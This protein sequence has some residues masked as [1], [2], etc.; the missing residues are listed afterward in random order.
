MNYTLTTN[1]SPDTYKFLDEE[2]KNSWRT[3]KAILEDALKIYEKMIM[4]AQIE[5]GLRD[6]YAEYK[7]INNEFTEVQFNSIRL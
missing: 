6:R 3:K 1:L 4:A 5:Q 7:E 2:S